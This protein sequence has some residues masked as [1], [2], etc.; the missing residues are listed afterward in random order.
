MTDDNSI[1]V[2]T[3]CTGSK[4]PLRAGATVPAE[5]I[6]TG[7]QHMRL[8]RG[9]KA[10][11]VA[12][13]PAGRLDLRVLSAQHGVLTGDALIGGYDATFA[14][15]PRSAVL[16]VAH[17]LDVPGDVALLLEAPRRLGLL[18][19]GN[20]YLFASQLT[21]RTRLGAPTIAFASP[22]ACRR[23][24]A[25]AGLFPIPLDNGDTTRFSCGLI[26][27]KGELAGR[28]LERLAQSPRARPPLDQSSLLA[29]LEH[30]EGRDDL[31][32]TFATAA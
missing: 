24:P 8:M 21:A 11:R 6:Y 29:W 2:L 14:G 26:G 31:S 4:L 30:P 15:M 5:Q 22:S 3:S 25:L 7:Q 17:A 16:Q 9:V 13:E 1:L 20:D 23:L 28:V 27:L 19:L 18:L 32:G 10:Y 12:G